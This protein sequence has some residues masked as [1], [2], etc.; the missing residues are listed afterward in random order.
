MPLMSFHTQRATLERP[1]AAKLF[2]T[3]HGEG[4]PVVA[5][6]LATLLGRL[7]RAGGAIPP[8][9]ATGYTVPFDPELFK[10]VA[11]LL[12]DAGVQLLFHAFASDVER[13]GPMYGVVFETKSGPGHPRP[14][15]GRLHRRWRRRG[16]R[17]RPYESAANR[18]ARAAD[19]PDVPH[20]AVRAGGVRR[21][22]A[23][24]S[25]AVARVHGLWDLIQK[26][27]AA[28]ELDL[29]REDI[30]FFG[31]PH[32]GEVSVNSTRVMRVLGTD[33]FDWSCAELESRRQ[34]RQIAAFLRRYVP[35]F[36]RAYIAQS[37]VHTGVRETRRIVGDYQL[38]RRGRARGA[39]V[40]R[41]GRARRLPGR[42]PQS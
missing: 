8:S 28:G 27:T 5:G 11:E 23:C 1:G 38:H 20:G 31:T 17:G 21:L 29:P 40:R 42:H 22:R 19:D 3:D 41:R 26:A 39:Q 25:R 7:V 15:G 33:V 13:D 10:L 2:P 24:A 35:G 9:L 30:L 32:E 16:A 18:T 6:A 37:G 36:E 12:D 34:M 4:E 14:R